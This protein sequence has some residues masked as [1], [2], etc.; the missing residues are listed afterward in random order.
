MYCANV[1]ECSAE[2]DCKLLAVGMVSV[3]EMVWQFCLGDTG[4]FIFS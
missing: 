1:D 2:L 3:A 4:D